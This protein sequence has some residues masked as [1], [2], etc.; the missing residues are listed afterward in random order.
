VGLLLSSLQLERRVVCGREELGA[1]AFGA[2]L[3]ALRK[4]LPEARKRDRDA[5]AAADPCR[6]GL[7]PVDGFDVLAAREP[8][9]A[10]RKSNAAPGVDVVRARPGLAAARCLV[11]GHATGCG[12]SFPVRV[13]EP[14]RDRV[15]AGGVRHHLDREGLEQDRAGIAEIPDA[16]AVPGSP[17]IVDREV[18]ADE[19]CRA[20]E[21]DAC[22]EAASAPPAAER[23]AAREDRAHGSA[24][25]DAEEFE[26]RLE[27]RSVGA[28]PN[29]GAKAGHAGDVCR[30]ERSEPIARHLESGRAGVDRE[31][32]RALVDPDV[33]ALARRIRRA[34]R[35]AEVEMLL[36][37]GR[38]EHEVDE[39]PADTAVGPERERLDLTR[40]RAAQIVTD[41]D[42][43]HRREGAARERNAEAHGLGVCRRETLSDEAHRDRVGQHRSDGL[44]STPRGRRRSAMT[45]LLLTENFPPAIGGTSRWFWELARRM[46]RGQVVVGAGACPGDAEFDRAHDTPVHRLPL[47]FD[48][49]GVFGWSGWRRYRRAA[50]AVALLARREGVRAVRCGRLVP[51][52]WIA[53]ASALPYACFVHG[54]ELAVARTSRQLSWMTRRVLAGAEFVIA[55][56]HHTAELLRSGWGLEPGRTRI[57]HPG[58]DAERFVSAPRD[59]AM[60]ER[61]G[62]AGRQVVL[63]V[64]RLQKRKGHDRVIEAVADLAHRFPDLLYAVVGDGEEAP[65]LGALARRLDVA[66]RVLFHGALDEESLLRAYQQCDVF[67]LANREVDGDFEGF[68]MVLL[69][70]EACCKPVIAGRSGGTGEAVLSGETALLI[71]GSDPREIAAAIA[72]LLDDPARCSRMGARG[73]IWV[74]E[75]FAFAGRMAEAARV[76]GLDGDL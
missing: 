57:L 13:R 43:L 15:V 60:R 70:A 45:T 4:L 76:L 3:Q 64:S 63:T 48:D 12:A 23:A 8:A 26:P 38:R 54:E 72:A 10:K 5:S 75:R 51:E 46:P 34:V 67:A 44:R 65:A 27:F 17:R 58:V 1:H 32:I 19:R 62:W 21:A 68:G 30:R 28:E 24:R 20:K 49:W 7:G 52:G 74:E 59:E 73:R 47:R 33:A 66:D 18:D 25:C 40:Q 69:E 42:V 11:H 41:L 29:A 36:R 37:P 9:P 53:R 56:G 14:P 50:R 35:D 22:R 71:D 31:S 55:N 39:R 2:C 16:A 6:R 61:L